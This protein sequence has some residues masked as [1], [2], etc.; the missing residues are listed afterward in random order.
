M[1]RVLTSPYTRCVQTVEPLAQRAGVEIEQR[2]E[3]AEGAPAGAVRDLLASLDGRTVA[4]CTHGDVIAQLIGPGHEAKKGSVWVLDDG[5][6][7]VEY[8]SAQAE[9]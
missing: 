2:A 1:A 6:S 9:S 5:L 3:L 7:P 4:A 8:L